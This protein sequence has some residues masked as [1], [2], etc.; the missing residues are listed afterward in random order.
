MKAADTVLPIGILDPENPKLTIE[1][2]GTLP[3]AT[4]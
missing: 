1:K 3:D 4:L 2:V